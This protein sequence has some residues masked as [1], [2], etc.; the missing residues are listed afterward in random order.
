MNDSYC[1]I[2]IL[3][4]SYPLGLYFTYEYDEYGDTIGAAISYK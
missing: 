3:P 2:G 4:A 1:E